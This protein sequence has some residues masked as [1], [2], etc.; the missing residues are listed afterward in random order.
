MRDLVCED[1][2]V[3]HDR[4]HFLRNFF[5]VLDDVSEGFRRVFPRENAEGRI[6]ILNLLV[7]GFRQL[8]DIVDC[9]A[10]IADRGAHVPRRAVKGSHH[11]SSVVGE[12]GGED[13]QIIKIF[14]DEIKSRL[15]ARQ[16]F[17]HILADFARV[18]NEILGA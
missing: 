6:R 7:K 3:V 9:R 2:R 14:I 4:I 16:G 15:S 8:G 13:V 10:D 18:A 12:R 17:A 5:R 11:L 1:S